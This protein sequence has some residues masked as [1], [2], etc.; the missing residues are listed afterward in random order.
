MVQSFHL[1]NSSYKETGSSRPLAWATV[2]NYGRR[3]KGLAGQVR[4][5]HYESSHLNI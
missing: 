2:L 1:F 5:S 4:W 3:L